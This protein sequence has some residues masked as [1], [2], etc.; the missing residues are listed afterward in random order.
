MFCR[1][2]DVSAG[3]SSL[4][5]VKKSSSTGSVGAACEEELVQAAMTEVGKQ[6][7][8]ALHKA[9]VGGKQPGGAR[10]LGQAL[11]AREEVRLLV[12]HFADFGEVF[13]FAFLVLIFAGDGLL[14][15]QPGEE[16]MRFDFLAFG[17]QAG[18]RA[19][20]FNERMNLGLGGLAELDEV[21]ALFRWE[22]VVGVN[23]G[24]ISCPRG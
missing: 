19:E 16:V 1:F 10:F 8:E 4:T 21:V 20:H 14:G 9:G 23:A 13:Q 24:R 5:A 15:V 12:A 11:D 2:S 18:I 22:E 7:R 17:Q 6:G 3:L